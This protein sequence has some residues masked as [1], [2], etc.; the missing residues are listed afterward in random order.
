VRE[1]AVKMAQAVYEQG[2]DRDGGLLYEADT[3]GSPIPTSIGGRRL[4]PWLAF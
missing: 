3:N 2:L 1:V 4:K